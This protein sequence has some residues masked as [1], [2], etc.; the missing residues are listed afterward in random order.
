MEH[1]D[2]TAPACVAAPHVVAAM[3]TDPTRRC[4]QPSLPTPG[5]ADPELPSWGR[6]LGTQWPVWQLARLAWLLSAALL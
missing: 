2:L 3:C 1:V 6:G 4:L 5:S